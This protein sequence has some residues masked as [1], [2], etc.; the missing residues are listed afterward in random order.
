[1]FILIILTKVQR[2]HHKEGPGSH[3]D[4][5]HGSHQDEGLELTLFQNETIYMV[6]K[7]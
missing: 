2:S 4:K 1:M 7:V 3:P 6:I 5:V